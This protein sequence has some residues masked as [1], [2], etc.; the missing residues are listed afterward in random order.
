MNLI[1][2]KLSKSNMY[3]LFSFILHLPIFFLSRSGQP[4]LRDLWWCIVFLSGSACFF[5]ELLIRALV[6]LVWRIVT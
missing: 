3:D 4:L 2:M 5:R 6:I 1:L